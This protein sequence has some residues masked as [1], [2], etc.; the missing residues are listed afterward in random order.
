MT[1]SDFAR[2]LDKPVPTDQECLKI[3]VEEARKQGKD[4]VEDPRIRALLG[5]L[6]DRSQAERR[7]WLH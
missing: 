5:H 4:P 2:L 3:L 7:E 1:E 6:T